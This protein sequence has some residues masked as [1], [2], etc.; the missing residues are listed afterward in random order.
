MITIEEEMNKSRGIITYKTLFSSSIYRF[1][2]AVL[3]SKVIRDEL[4]LVSL[5][6]I[7]ER[8]ELSFI[9]RVCL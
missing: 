9:H 2:L 1:I 5:S 4:A 8:T 7:E 6:I 3:K